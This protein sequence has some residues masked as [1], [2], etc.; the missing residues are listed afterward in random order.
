MPS[1]SSMGTGSGIDIRS[2]IDK[3]VAAEGEARVKKLDKDETT[4]LN[5][6][7]GYSNLKNTLVD[8]KQS[9]YNLKNLDELTKRTAS[10]ADTSIYTAIV[11]SSNVK[12]SSYNIQVNTLAKAQKLSSID[13][14]S[15][16]TLVGT[17][18]LEF[19][20]D[21]TVYSLDINSQNQSLSG[22]K[23]KINETFK[24]AGIS[25]SLVTVDTGTRLILS[26]Q[27]TGIENSFTV[28]VIQDGDSNNTNN[29]GLSQ[30]ISSNLTVIQAASDASIKIDNLTVTSSENSIEDAI[31]GVTINLIKADPN[32]DHNLSLSLDK[33]STQS[34]ITQFV[35]NYNATLSM[36]RDLSGYESNG[37][38]GQAGVLIGDA[39]V[40]SIQESLRKEFN[41][42]ISTNSAIGFKLLSQI[43]IT[44][45][46]KTGELQIDD[47]K[48]SN[49]LDNN[50]DDVGNLFANET[51]GLALRLDKVLNAYTQTGGVLYSRIIGMNES[52]IDIKKQRIDL[53][54]RLQKLEQ[55]LIS[56]FTTMDSIVSG[57]NSMGDFLKRT[58]DGLVEPNSIRK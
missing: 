16:S 20:I 25:A 39:T 57:L 42:A 3:L 8:F 31:E 48:L 46:A 38:E 12:S 49:S 28:S 11:N 15:S 52:I 4:K 21:N 58:I 18:T 55:R 40:R 32:I 47:S 19:T 51:D 27:K 9:L 35:N 6:I 14:A 17:G 43:G 2:L 22:I 5:K 54:M 41:T 53:E 50:L 24:E 10:S 29:A 26:A 7:T 33:S 37:F 45:N 30:L 36:I 13:F 1:I 44:T 34:K 23:D 56:Q